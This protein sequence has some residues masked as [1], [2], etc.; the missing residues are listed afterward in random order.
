MSRITLSI[1]AW[2]LGKKYLQNSYEAVHGKKSKEMPQKGFLQL[3][4]TK[5][6]SALN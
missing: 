4:E 1:V 3:R 6:L 5:K 2:T